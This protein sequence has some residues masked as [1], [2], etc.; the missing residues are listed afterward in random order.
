[1]QNRACTLAP[2][3]RH[4]GRRRTVLVNRGWVP[5]ASLTHVRGS[6]GE[7]GPAIPRPEGNVTVRGCVVEGEQ[8]RRRSS[9]APPGSLRALTV[10]AAAHQLLAASRRGDARVLL[11]RRQN[12][13]EGAGCGRGRVRGGADERYGVGR[14]ARRGLFADRTPEGHPE[15][16]LPSNV[17]LAAT[18]AGPWPLP[19]PLSSYTDFYIAPAVHKGYSATWCAQSGEGRGGR[20]GGGFNLTALARRYGLSGVGL[21]MTFKLLRHSPVMRR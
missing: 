14:G 9:W 21:Y 17:S 13:G 6:G 10:A 8:V 2:D 15:D 12:Y 7:E 11:A 4:A 16:Q 5:Q 20:R 3:P 18:R 19:R 1:M